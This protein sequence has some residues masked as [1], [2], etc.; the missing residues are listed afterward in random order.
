[1]HEVDSYDGFFGSGHETQCALNRKWS[2]R[3]LGVGAP[4]VGDDSLNLAWRFGIGVVQDHI[5]TVEQKACGP[6]AANDAAA[7]QTNGVEPR[8]R[9]HRFTNCSLSRTA[10]ADM[11][12]AFMPPKMS[13]ARVTSSALVASCP[14]PR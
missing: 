7:Q 6:S 9:A 10:C 3:E 4:S 1:M 12:L 11:I 8:N 13:T 2:H 5:D 14:A